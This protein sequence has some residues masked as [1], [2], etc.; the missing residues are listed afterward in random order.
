MAISERIGNAARAANIEVGHCDCKSIARKCAGGR[1]TDAAGCPGY[2]RDPLH[3]PP[4]NCR[5]PS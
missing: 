1:L 5:D 2:N 4:Q 3:T